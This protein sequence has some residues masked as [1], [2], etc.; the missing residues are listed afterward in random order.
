MDYVIRPLVAEDESILWE[1]LYHGL[2]S[3]AEQERPSREI[4]H[5]PEFS[6]YVAGW[7]RAGDTGFV[8]HDKK[9]GSLLG[10]VWLRRPIGKTHTPPQLALA[11]KPEHRGHG[12]G[13]ALLTQLVRANPEQSTISLR[14]V[15][16]K[17][18]LR[19]YERFGFKVIEKK[20]GAVVMHRE[21]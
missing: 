6:R 3:L 14:F 13:T 17:P 7:G 4:V 21:A 16:G 19:L 12:I 8:A 15:A 9:D 18:V 1:M 5:R 20:P 2:S 11:V 10:A